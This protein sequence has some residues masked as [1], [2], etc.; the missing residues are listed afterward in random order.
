MHAVISSLFMVVCNVLLIS[1]NPRIKYP[2]SESGEE[3]GANGQ[4]LFGKDSWFQNFLLAAF[5]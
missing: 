5:Q 4:T 2:F 1:T 3:R